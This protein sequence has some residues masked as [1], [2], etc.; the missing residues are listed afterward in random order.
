MTAPPG[1]TLRTK[2]S[3]LYVAR[4]T[5]AK[6]EEAETISRAAEREGMTVPAFIRSAALHLARGTE[7]VPT[8]SVRVD[9]IDPAKLWGL[10][11][12]AQRAEV[13]A[14]RGAWF[15][16]DGLGEVL[17]NCDS[18]VHDRGERCAAT[19]DQDNPQ[20][21]DASAW[22]ADNCHGNGRPVPGATGCPGHKPKEKP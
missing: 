18:C 8:V 15:D 17:T 1:F 14:Q 5:T 9:Q 16:P 20:R 12:E 13:L 11:T 2:G 10:M 21:F 3:P 19:E 22:A 6:R 7:P 4:L